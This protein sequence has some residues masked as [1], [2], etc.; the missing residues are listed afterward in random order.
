MLVNKRLT[1]ANVNLLRFMFPRY[2]LVSEVNALDEINKPII[3]KGDLNYVDSLVKR[4][5][6][7]GIDFIIV[8]IYSDINLEDRRILAN[9]VFEK[10]R[11]GVLPQYL[12]NIIDDIDR[13]DF[14]EA[15]KIKWVSGKWTIH[16]INDEN[17]FLT[18]V[19]ALN[20]SSYDFIK[21]YFEVLENTKPYKLESSIL[22]FLQ[23]AKN[24]SYNGTS[25]NYRKKL[26]IYKGKK[27]DNTIKAIDSSLE[28]QI[29]NPELRL[30]NLLINILDSSKS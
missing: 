13:E 20:K 9:I 4:C 8:G 18:L 10:W 11:N 7:K 23:R 26:D 29:D 14:I 24:K 30:M 2:K 5:Q 3:Y 22:T 19:D 17:T 12:E 25:F 6:E 1:V 21:T 15:I 28:Y 16:K 27:L